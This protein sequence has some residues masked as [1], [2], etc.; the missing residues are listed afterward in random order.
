MRDAFCQGMVELNAARP[1]IFLT[2]DLGFKALEPLRETLGARFINAGVA[3]QNMVSVAAGL[4]ADGQSVWVYSIAPFLYAR[5]FEQIRNDV[6]MHDLDVKLVGNGGGYGYGSMGATHH[7]LE[8]YGI[9][10]TL[11][12]MRAY[13]PAFDEDVPAVLRSMAARP[14]PSYLRLGR[15]EKPAG[16]AVPAYAPWR[17]LLD[18]GGPVLI[19]VGP[20]VGALWAA[21]TSLPLVQRPQIWVWSELPLDSPPPQSLLASLEKR[22]R[23]AVLEEHV[24]QGG[25]G[26]MLAA[27][28]LKAGVAVRSFDHFSAQG[29]PSGNYGSQQFHRLESGLDPKS[30]LRTLGVP[31]P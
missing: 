28:L 22:G 11:R 13:V 31:L 4:A 18:G 21:C 5:P 19:G 24:A 7:A 20:L 23:L 2:G 8:D 16:A 9:L 3:E 6:C 27:W 1:Y 10:L 29:Y 17:M 26:Q 14:H 15:G 25:A 12:H 30:V